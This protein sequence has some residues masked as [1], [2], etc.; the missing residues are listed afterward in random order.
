MLAAVKAVQATRQLLEKKWLPDNTPEAITYFSVNDEW[1]YWAEMDNKV[2]DNCLENEFNTFTGN[3]LRS[4]FPYLEIGGIE[5]VWAKVHPNCRCKL[6]RVLRFDR[7]N[8]TEPTPKNKAEADIPVYQS[9]D[10]MF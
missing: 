5:L 2:C 3:Q 7:Y 6:I 10:L 1:V 4:K 9:Y 8:W